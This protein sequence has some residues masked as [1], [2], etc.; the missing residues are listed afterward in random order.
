MDENQIRSYFEP[1]W[2]FR[3]FKSVNFFL[4][5][6]GIPLLIFSIGAAV[7]AIIGALDPFRCNLLA[8]PAGPLMAL[9]AY[10][11]FAIN[12]PKLIA[13]VYPAFDTTPEIFGSVIKMWADKLANPPIFFVL[14]GLVV[15]LL[16]YQNLNQMWES[17]V[18]LGDVWASNTQWGTFFKW[19][20]GIIDVA[21]GGFLLGSGAIG[22]LGSVIVV[23]DLMKLPLK[24]SHYRSLHAIGD[25][26]IGL[27][28]WAL[29]GLALIG[30][31][32]AISAPNVLCQANAP[33]TID[34]GKILSN[35]VVSIFST[36]AVISGFGLPAYYA[37]QAIIRAKTQQ[38]GRL[39]DTQNGIYNLVNDL[40]KKL[41]GTT[42]PTLKKIEKND[43]QTED[44]GNTSD[45]KE[46]QYE[47]NLDE[48][49][50]S[51]DR[52]AEINK[53][54]EE[55]EAIPDWPI[56]WQ[57]VVKIIGAG[58]MPFATNLL[59]NLLPDLAKLLGLSS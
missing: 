15:A 33:I 40:T 1:N 37:H 13:K 36:I 21:I 53:M 32:R 42:S 7:A 59:T 9:A 38:I 12:F 17:K 44:E 23:R 48:L 43:S 4:A 51:Y 5:V 58:I 19:Y 3:L 34:T 30:P 57:G 20:Y 27:T 16:N 18:W 8:Y 52:I 56:T 6:I 54:I 50:R 2:V 49:R 11:W 10:G 26:S 35:L 25:L 55:V 41:T 47:Q 39:Q 45:G 22:I 29:V 24:L 14:A 46:E 28:V 31:I